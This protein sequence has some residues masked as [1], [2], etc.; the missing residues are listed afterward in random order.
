M[1]TELRRLAGRRPEG[2]VGL[3]RWAVALCVGG[4][5]L[6][7]ACSGDD[8]AATDGGGIG[9]GG[10]DESNILLDGALPQDSGPAPC[11]SSVCGAGETCLNDAS[12]VCSPGYVPDGNGGCTPAAAGTPSSHTQADVCQHWKDGHVVTTPKPFTAGQNQCDVGTLAAGGITDTLVRTNMYR[13]MEGLDPVTDDAT[14][15]QGDQACAVIQAWNNPKSLSN[16]HSPPNTATC[17]NAL[18]AT[19]SGQSNLAWGTSC[20]DSIDLY[21]SDPGN[22]TT[23]GHRRWVL[24]PNLGKV[25]VG[26]YEGGNN[27]Y[28]G[29]A[30]CLGVFDTSGTGPYPAW[31]SWP[32][33]GYVPKAVA[34]TT[35]WSFHIKQKSV[36]S[37]AVI[38][39]K[40]MGANKDVAVST[41]KLNQ[42]FGDD[43]I[44]FS[45]SGWTPQVGDVY[46][47]SVT[48]GGSTY[49]YDVLPV[50]CP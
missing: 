33:S 13:W 21:V 26:Y 2:G 3:G 34:Q 8:S 49:V 16:P 42:G 35:P 11:G 20:A 46:R 9:D 22:A 44:S 47:V 50:D 37:G 32:P 25:G 38:A 31:Y 14:K 28:Q 6:L 39:V 30:Q 45:P 1:A 41:Q 24:H 19:W 29:K 18:G 15:D 17:Y 5:A 48:A 36:I 4:S 23:L 27:G 7:L 10:G 40:D 12:C 43:A